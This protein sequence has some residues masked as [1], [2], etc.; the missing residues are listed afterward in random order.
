[1]AITK[2][3]VVVFA[4]ASIAAGG[5]KAAPSAGG[6]GTGVNCMNYGRSA[7]S[8][9]IKNGATAPTAAGVITFQTSHDNVKWF[10]YQTVGGNTTNNGEE[11]QSIVLD[12]WVQYVRVLCYGNA[13]N[14]VTFEVILN[15]VV[16]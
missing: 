6:T 4:E 11:S 5:T 1:M 10:D 9:R 14:A 15:A 16:A 12:A 3:D 7:L 8:Y 2:E 13:T